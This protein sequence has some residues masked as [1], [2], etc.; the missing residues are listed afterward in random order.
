MAI[1]QKLFFGQS[2][3]TSLDT[4]FLEK[5]KRLKSQHGDNYYPS[6]RVV[7]GYTLPSW[8]REL[9]WSTE[10]KIRF[11]ESAFLGFY[12]GQWVY[13]SFDWSDDNCALPFS[14]ILIDGQQRFNAL[15]EYWNDKFKVFDLFWS[16]LEKHEKIRFLR[17]QF[18]STEVSINDEGALREMYD[19]LNFGGTPHL[20]TERAVIRN[21]P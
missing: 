14:G 15:E 17:T 11:I 5:E 20:P 9:T 2:R 18:A 16:D 12:L 21:K 1:P 8:Q 10:Q 19:R 7:C 6:G 4:L 3:C 13:N